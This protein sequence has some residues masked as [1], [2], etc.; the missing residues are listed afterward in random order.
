MMMKISSRTKSENITPKAGDYE[1]F[2]IV[3]SSDD[4]SDDVGEE[5]R[6]QFGVK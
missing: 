4:N 6:H 2:L 3:S 5:K 1:G